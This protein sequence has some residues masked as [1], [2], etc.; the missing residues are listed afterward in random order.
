MSTLDCRMQDQVMR[1]QNLF[2]DEGALRFH[3]AS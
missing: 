1:E 3:P 2:I